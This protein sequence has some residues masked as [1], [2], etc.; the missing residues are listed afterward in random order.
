MNNNN[1][2][3]NNNNLYEY[4]NAFIQKKGILLNNLSF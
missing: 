1:M 2:D 3:M 4:K